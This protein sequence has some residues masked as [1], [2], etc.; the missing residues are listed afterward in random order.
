MW[1]TVTFTKNMLTAER[2]LSACLSRG[3]QSSVVLDISLCL[4]PCHSS[5]YAY[6]VYVHVCAMTHMW[7]TRDNL[8]AHLPHC[9]GQGLLFL[10]AWRVPRTISVFAF[11]LHTPVLGLLVCVSRP[12]FQVHSGESNTSC[13]S[14][15]AVPASHPSS[16][17]L[18][19]WGS[20]RTTSETITCALE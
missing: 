7:R 11:H 4:S 14:A 5:V 18:D 8:G 12:G 10:T 15:S 2:A 13:C 9:L 19:T 3:Q 17:I 20:V 16:P 1:M 6:T